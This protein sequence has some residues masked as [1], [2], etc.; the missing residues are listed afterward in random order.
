MQQDYADPLAKLLTYGALEFRHTNKPWPNYL[1]LGFTKE[2]VQELIR[3][4]TDRSLNFANQDTLDVWAPVHAWR[5]LGQLQ[6]VEATEP[7]VRLFGTLE[8]DDWTSSELPKVFSLIGPCS[9]PI[10]AEFM[11][12]DDVDEFDRISIPACLERIA[13]D[14]PSS[15]DEV[16]GVLTRQL[17][18]RATNG[19]TFNAFLISGLS[20]LKA[21]E[22]MDVIHRAF[23]EECVDLRVLGDIEDVEIEM[24]LRLTR[25]T[26]RP[27]VQLVPGLPPLDENENWV[28]IPED[29]PTETIMNPF[30]GIGRNDSCP[31]GS[32]KKYKKCCL[33]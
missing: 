14:H 26:P 1:E 13:L 11:A 9:V 7:L 19:H 29:L 10:I 16:V 25:E 21:S 17:E 15:R 33:H 24:G 22:S 12:E 4:A 2:H 3:M 5:V 8:H 32:G 23:S 20:T 31:C 18:S 30:K 28:E 6:A 27:E